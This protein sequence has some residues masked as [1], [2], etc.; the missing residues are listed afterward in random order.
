VLVAS[1]VGV[2]DIVDDLC[3]ASHD[4]DA[5]AE[6]TDGAAATVPPQP[7][8]PASKLPVIADR[9][10]FMMGRSKLWRHVSWVAPQCGGERSNLSS[11]MSAP[12]ALPIS[13]RS[14]R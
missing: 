13:N 5:A 4:V 6:V 2:A 10:I 3:G 11:N 9:T 12:I 1:V 14:V 8:I 7:E